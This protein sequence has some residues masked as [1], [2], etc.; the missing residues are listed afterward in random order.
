MKYQEKMQAIGLR[1]QGKSYFDI[2]KIVK[3]SKGTLSIWLKDVPLTNEQRE[4]LFVTRRQ[5]NILKLA[6]IRRSQKKERERI[7]ITAAKN[8]ATKHMSNPLFLSGLMLYWAEGDKTEKAFAVKFSN[9][10]P[11]M[12]KLMMRWFREVCGVAEE[13]FRISLH[14]HEL[15]HQQEIE[16]YWSDITG[17]PQNHFYKTWIKETSLRHR[18]N[19]LY[20]G[21]C[22]IRI[23]DITL[24]RRIHGWKLTVLETLRIE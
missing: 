9:S 1:K 14:I 13:R 18:K 21:T 7:T 22:A 24:L 4:N 11:R 5:K 19:V 2:L 3:V 10:D 20:N 12:I 6:E 16:Q 15:Q 8:E 17:I 23:G